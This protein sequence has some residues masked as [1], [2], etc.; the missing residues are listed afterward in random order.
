[1]T[2]T[3]RLREL[4]AKGTQGKWEVDDEELVTIYGGSW[5]VAHTAMNARVTDKHSPMCGVENAA[6]IAEAITALPGLLDEVD[7]LRDAYRAGYSDAEKEIS[8]T[9]LG[10]SAEAA[11]AQNHQLRKEADRLREALSNIQELNMTGADENG[12]CWAH[13]DLIEQEIRA[14]LQSSEDKP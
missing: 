11:H 2:D 8:Q 6:L 1:M 9:A 4:L 3:A 13:S 7:R 5:G 10:Q 12:L 14:A